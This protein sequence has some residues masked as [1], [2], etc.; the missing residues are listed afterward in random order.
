[1]HGKFFKKFS[2]VGMNYIPLYGSIRPAVIFYG[3]DNYALAVV[4]VVFADMDNGQL[5]LYNL[6]ALLLSSVSLSVVCNAPRQMVDSNEF[7][8]CIYIGILF[9]LTFMHVPIGLAG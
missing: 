4:V 6:V 8:C 3:Q 5:S 1:M 9:S 7:I 2:Q